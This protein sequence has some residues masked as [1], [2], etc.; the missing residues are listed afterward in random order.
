[1]TE[2]TGLSLQDFKSRDPMPPGFGTAS[3]VLANSNEVMNKSR[4]LE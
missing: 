3:A 1:M 4:I 2:R